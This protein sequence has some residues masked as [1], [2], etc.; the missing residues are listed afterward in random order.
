MYTTITDPVPVVCDQQKK[1]L[2][3]DCQ[4]PSACTSGPTLHT[5]YKPLDM[6]PA[7][8][9]S[10]QNLTCTVV[11]IGMKGAAP[12]DNLNI[13]F[14]DSVT[15]KPGRAGVTDACFV[16]ASS[17]SDRPKTNYIQCQQDY[18]ISLFN[19]VLSGLESS[20]QKGMYGFVPFQTPKP[21]S[22]QS[23]C[24]LLLNG[25]PSAVGTCEKDIL[26]CNSCT[27]PDMCTTIPEQQYNSSPYPIFAG[28]A[29]RET[30]RPN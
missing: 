12:D 5:T 22:A 19:T 7:L 3:L 24:R 10:R 28:D 16:V 9:P 23:L 25:D 30:V 4:L 20:T 15:L 13:P 26:V 21:V 8:G 27:L 29:Q 11:E 17:P 2:C 1:L 14:M 18:P 6:L